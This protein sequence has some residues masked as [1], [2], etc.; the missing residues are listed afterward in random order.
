MNSINTSAMVRQQVAIQQTQQSGTTEATSKASSA[1]SVS[2]SPMINQDTSDV[3]RMGTA[4]RLRV[5]E[6][7]AKEKEALTKIRDDMS[8]E[9]MEKAD[10]VDT[11]SLANFAKRKRSEVEEQDRDY[12]RQAVEDLLEELKND[13]SGAE[14]ASILENLKNNP[15][16][17]KDVILKEAI[18]N[19]ITSIIQHSLST[20]MELASTGIMPKD[21]ILSGSEQRAVC[22]EVVLGYST[23]EQF[24]TSLETKV[25]LDKL[26]ND[27]AGV[28][29]HTM[30]GLS[31][32]MDAVAIAGGGEKG[33]VYAAVSGISS[34]QQLTGV[35]QQAQRMFDRMGERFPSKE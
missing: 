2:S 7:K 6:G 26:N 3:A 13:F 27:F 11:R 20:Q 31:A 35:H 15:V 16:V 24:L 32:S 22:G 28:L 17:S 14:S 18:E 1:S 23:Q 30:A 5:R 34:L 29:S 25:G 12:A 10:Q 8:Q 4:G 33:A 9:K 19:Q 21:G